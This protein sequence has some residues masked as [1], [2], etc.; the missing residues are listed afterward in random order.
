MVRQQGPAWPEE[1]PTATCERP[2]SQHVTREELVG[3][4]EQGGVGQNLTLEAATERGDSLHCSGQI[5]GPIRR[6]QS[7]GSACPSRLQSRPVCL[8][9]PSSCP[10]PSRVTM[11][12]DV[13]PWGEGGA[14]GPAGRIAPSERAAS[15]YQTLVTKYPLTEL[16]PTP[17]LCPALWGRAQ[18]A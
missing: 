4:E 7:L 3:L 12:P 1:T 9:V 5:Y 8:P 2:W 15:S 16:P 17:G 13:P 6:I 11:D 18:W 10:R 14:G